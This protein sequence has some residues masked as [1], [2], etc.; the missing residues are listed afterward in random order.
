MPLCAGWSAPALAQNAD[1]PVEQVS[2]VY[3]G[4][5]LLLFIGGAVGVGWY[6]WWSDRREK[7]P[8]GEKPAG[9]SSAR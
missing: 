7:K 4:L 5:F 9:G 3:T 2:P 8:E 6:M 1:V